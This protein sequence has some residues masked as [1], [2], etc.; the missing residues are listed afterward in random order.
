M[1]ATIT[2]RERTLAYFLVSNRTFGYIYRTFSTS[3]PCEAIT[4][5]RIRKSNPSRRAPP[6][7]ANLQ[8]KF[9]RSARILSSLRIRFFIGLEN[10]SSSSLPLVKLSS[11]FTSS[12]L[13]RVFYLSHAFI[14][15]AVSF[16]FFYL[17]K[18]RLETRNCNM[19]TPDKRYR[20]NQPRDPIPIQRRQQF[21]H[22]TVFQF[23]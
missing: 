13:G 18:T 12:S 19:E 6:T 21:S 20:T 5:S 7:Y 17:I 16:F 22:L 23:A 10:I 1:L 15:T 3:R 14:F 9:R 2:A 11:L 4:R 8:N